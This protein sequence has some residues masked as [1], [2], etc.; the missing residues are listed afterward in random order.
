MLNGGKTTI[1]RTQLREFENQ[2]QGRVVCPIDPDYA[3][4]KNIWNA[5]VKHAPGAIIQ[6]FNAADI[7][8]AVQFAADCGIEM[9][10]RGGGHNHTGFAVSDGG[11]M[12]DLTAMTSIHLNI[13]R[14]RMHAQPGLTY[15]A[16]DQ[17]G[18]QVGLATTGPIVSMV[19]LPGYTLGGGIGWLHRK[20]GAACD[21]L[22]GAEVV[23]AS[24]ETVRASGRENEEL[25]WALRGGGGNFG[26]VSRLDY[27]LHSLSHVMAGLIF[28]PLETIEQVGEFVDG[29]MDD[30][31]DDLNVWMLHRAAPALP[32][33][34]ASFHGKPALI[35][36][37]TWTGRQTEFE[38]VIEPLNEAQK[39]I[40]NLVHWREYA[41]WQRSLD[42]A[43]TN[44][45]CNE[46]VGGYL[47]EYSSELRST[48]AQFVQNASSPYSDFKVARLGGE[49]ER[50]GPSE[51]AF[52]PRDA[53]Y[54][55]VIQTRWLVGDD[56]T[57]HLKWTQ[58]FHNQL[59]NFD[60]GR[61]YSNFIGAEEPKER[62]KDAWSPETHE[63]LSRLKSKYDPSNFF[64][65]N[66]NVLPG[67]QLD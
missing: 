22:V 43:W 18:Q 54:A 4:L 9:S 37:V 25:F 42:G 10:V 26:V 41:E 61:T 28:Y 5:R 62:F 36:A 29:Y 11:L 35:L 6:A 47:D 32:A 65:R 55:Y 2:L 33:L 52:G 7:S 14:H 23:L 67:S 19:G 16:F 49:F 31:P 34:P 44:G 3:V 8:K 15:T 45:L 12:L 51:T 66:V 17:A 64:R 39:P 50:V 59:R 53:R 30:A 38:N 1:C 56:E 20:F 60:T 21:N 63:R 40:A 57:S 48:I 58:A 27:K 13:D 46:W 24:G